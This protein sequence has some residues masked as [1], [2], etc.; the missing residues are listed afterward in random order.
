M[1]CV[2]NFGQ[3]SFACNMHE[4]LFQNPLLFDYL[5]FFSFQLYIIIVSVLAALQSNTLGMTTIILHCL[6]LDIF[7]G[8]TTGFV[9]IKTYVYL[10]LGQQHQQ[11]IANQ[12]FFFREG[13]VEFRV[14]N[15]Y[16]FAGWGG[17]FIFC[18][19]T[20]HLNFQGA[21]PN[22]LSRLAHG[23]IQQCIQLTQPLCQF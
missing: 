9:A 3:R 21:D 14:L 5:T 18:N 8:E 1:C 22:P 2:N 20:T 19:F 6:Q 10:F 7:F 17:M 13:E 15:V 4:V 12:N 11:K 16:V 23:D